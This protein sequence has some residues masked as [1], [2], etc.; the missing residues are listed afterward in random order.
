M[1]DRRRRGVVD[2]RRHARRDARYAVVYP[3]FG[4]DRH[5]CDDSARYFGRL[6]PAAVGQVPVHHAGRG[7]SERSRHRDFRRGRRGGHHQLFA[8]ALMAAEAL[9]RRDGRGAH[10]VHGRFAQ[11]GVAVEGGRRDLY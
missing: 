6:H 10:G 11:Q 2:H 8:P 9:A 4:R 1:S 7:R 3:A 5:L